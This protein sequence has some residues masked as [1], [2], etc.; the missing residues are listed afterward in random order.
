MNLLL[1]KS[2]SLLKCKEV[3]FLHWKYVLIMFLLYLYGTLESQGTGRF[4]IFLYN[5]VYTRVSRK[6]MPSFSIIS[7]SANLLGLLSAVNLIFWQ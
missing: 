5:L 3:L 2:N 4:S 1:L 6:I 7:V